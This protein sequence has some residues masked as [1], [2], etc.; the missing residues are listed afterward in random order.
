[1]ENKQLVKRD[2]ME[3]T[4][5][6]DNGAEVTL[7]PDIIKN[8]LVNGNGAIT[9]QEIMMFL[10]LCKA[11]RLNPF[12]RQ[13][14]LIKYGNSPA[15]IITGKDTFTIRAENHP[16][17]RG[18]NSGVI[19]EK[20][21][22]LEYREGTLVLKGETLVGGWA[23]IYRDDR[24]VPEESTVN[25]EEYCQYTTDKYSG[26]KRPNAMWGK[27]PGVMIRKIAVVSALREAFPDAFSGLYSPEEM[28]VSMEAL[29]TVP[30]T[31]KE[32]NTEKNV[33]Q[34]KIQKEEEIEVLAQEEI[35]DDNYYATYAE[36]IGKQE[37]VVKVE[38]KS[39]MPSLYTCEMCGKEIS[40]R[41][42]AY[43]IKK[44]GKALCYE[45]QGKQ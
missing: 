3:I 11:Q 16:H 8:Y 30:V 18:K 4:Y 19:I 2:G 10:E 15:T 43:T 34:K 36:P 20:G 29:P 25:F 31:V 23:K 5:Y 44:Y 45:C 27:M 40:D 6:T 12:L 24:V 1:M 38:E 37:T 28:P 42:G 39:K 7:S 26:E 35:P 33:E 14:Y 32:Q 9:D 21:G 17:Y 13:C 41:I 22:K